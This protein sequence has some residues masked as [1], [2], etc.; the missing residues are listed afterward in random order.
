ML[1]LHTSALL[2]RRAQTV[3]KWWSSGGGS[4]NPSNQQINCFL[5]QPAVAAAAPG[6]PTAVS[7]YEMCNS[8][9]VQTPLT[10]INGAQY[11][12]VFMYNDYSDVFTITAAFDGAQASQLF[13]G[14]PRSQRLRP[15]PQQATCNKGL[16]G[17]PWRPSSSSG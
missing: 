4:N 3:D 5:P 16:A 15:Q 17:G 9:Y 8:Q 2:A 1:T 7:T 12:S 14:A 13:Y 6:V 11:G 10:G